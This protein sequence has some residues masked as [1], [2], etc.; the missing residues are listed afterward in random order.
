MKPALQSANMGQE[1]P[2]WAMALLGTGA[3]V[4]LGVGIRHA[5]QYGSSD[6]Q[7]SGSHLLWRHIDPWAERLAQSPHRF[8]HFSPPNYLHLLYLLFLPFAFL[9]FTVVQVLWCGCSILCSLAAVWVLVR[10][11]ALSKMQGFAVLALLWISSPF[12]VVLEVGQLSLFELLFFCLVFTSRSPLASGF[13][14]GISLV[15]YSFSPVAGMFLFWRRRYGVL[16]I[17]AAVC[18]TGLL[19][20]FLLLPTPFLQLM[21]EPFL[22]S[23]IAVNPGVADLMTLSEYGLR[24]WIGI[25]PAKAMSYVVAMGGGAVFALTLSRL[26]VTK[27]AELC[28]L[29]LASLLFFKHLIYDYVFLVIPLCYAFSLRTSRKVWVPIVGG[30]FVFWFFAVLLHRATEGMAVNLAAL[31][32]NCILLTLLLGYTTW[33]A[34]QSARKQ[35]D[36]RF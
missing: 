3:M 14:F 15:K 31:S 7:W 35:H 23:R 30:V 24:P 16:L 20:C 32:A 5:L 9:P 29:S 13:A 1:P 11:F 2:P 17:A 10:Y 26:R 6:L 22:V 19:G 12:R 25:A 34:I 27:A 4:S 33:V 8:S 21:R 18:C 28:L 36:P